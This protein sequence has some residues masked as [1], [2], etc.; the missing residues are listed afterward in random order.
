MLRVKQPTIYGLDNSG[1]D[2]GWCKMVDLTAV[3]NDLLVRR[4]FAPM[5]VERVG[6]RLLGLNGDRHECFSWADGKTGKVDMSGCRDHLDWSNPDLLIP[7]EVGN[8]LIETIKKQIDGRHGGAQ[9]FRIR[10]C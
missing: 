4:S 7:A 1:L 2:W 6:D 3:V 9:G 5:P 8:K 10:G